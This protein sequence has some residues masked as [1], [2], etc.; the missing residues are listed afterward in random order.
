MF[1]F[2]SMLLLCS[3]FRLKELFQVKN[4]V[5]TSLLFFLLKMPKIWVGRTTVNGEKKEDEL[6]LKK[7]TSKQNKTT[8]KKKEKKKS[9]K[10]IGIKPRNFHLVWYLLTTTLLRMNRLVW[11]KAFDLRP[12]PWNFRRQMSFKADQ[13]VLNTSS[14]IC[15]RKIIQL[16]TVKN[17]FTNAFH[18]ELFKRQQHVFMRLPCYSSPL[19]L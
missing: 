19:F 14:K 9:F 11:G 10:K 13:A 1:V 16:L 4:A 15:F 8:K 7:K 17:E 6:I 12:F 18:V 3:F 2:F 5:T